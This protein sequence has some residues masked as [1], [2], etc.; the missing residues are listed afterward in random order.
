MVNDTPAG[1]GRTGACGSASGDELE[2]AVAVTVAVVVL[3]AVAVVVAPMSP[4]NVG[5]GE[6][7]DFRR[8]TFQTHPRTHALL[9][10]RR[11][12]TRR[13]VHF[14]IPRV[15]SSTGTATKPTKYNLPVQQEV[16]HESNLKINC[17]N[18]GYICSPIKLT[19]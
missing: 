16:R 8:P 2:V 9:Y 13:H 10:N 5:E 3:G 14:S 1:N 12:N 4:V 15:A 18:L 7:D 6:D 19:L 17:A 11:R